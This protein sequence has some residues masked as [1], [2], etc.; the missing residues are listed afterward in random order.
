M[1]VI[2]ILNYI[3]NPLIAFTVYFCFLHS[4]RHIISIAYDLDTENFN[5]GIKIFIKKAL[6]LTIVTIL[7]YILAIIILSFSYGLNEVV[8]SNI[9]W[10]GV[11]NFS[12]YIA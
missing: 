7:L 6:P 10:F 5:N 4:I 3:F 8:I 1:F 2:L 9:Y 12:A 11:I